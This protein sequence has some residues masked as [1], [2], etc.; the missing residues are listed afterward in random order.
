[1]KKVKSKR[2]LA[3]IMVLVLLAVNDLSFAAFAD[4]PEASQEI[5]ATG[6][7][8]PEAS[9]TVP[10]ETDLPVRQENTPASEQAEISQ[11]E[12]KAAQEETQSVPEK[13]EPI[14]EENPSA[15]SAQPEDEPAAQDKPAPEETPA[16]PETGGAEEIDPAPYADS[17]AITINYIFKD[18]KAMAARPHIES[19][20]AGEAVSKSISSPEVPGYEPLTFSQLIEIPSMDKDVSYDVFYV[21]KGNTPYKVN[22]YQQDLDQS[23]Y[24]L[25][26]VENRRGRTGTAVTAESQRYIGFTDP[27]V[28]PSAQISP[29]GNTELNVYYT[30][31]QYTMFFNTGE[32]GSYIEPVTALYDQPLTLP[33]DPTRPGYSFAGWGAYGFPSRMPVGDIMMTAEWEIAGTVSYTLV[34]WLESIEGN[35]RYDH[36][37]A[38]QISGPAESVP[39]IPDSLPGGIHFPIDQKHFTFNE[40]K[41]NEEKPA[42]ISGTGE[43]IVN[44]FYDRK[45]YTL[46]FEFDDSKYTL[47]AGGKTYNTSPYTLTAKYGAPIADQW[48]TEAP[49][50]RPGQ[51]DSGTFTGWIN[52]D[53]SLYF[54]SVQFFLDE[55]HINSNP[56][57]ANWKSN[58]RNVT[59]TY[60]FENLAGNGETADY[61]QALNVARESR[62]WTAKQFVGFTPTKNRE[63]ITS[64]NTATFHY[65]RNRYQMEF[66]NSGVIDRTV[67]S[68]KYEAPISGLNYTPGTP[69]SL[70]GYTFGGWFTTPQ[71]FPGSEYHFTGKTMPAYNLI[72]YAKWVKPT[73][74]VTFMPGN[75][76]PS[77]S[78]RILLQE[79][80]EEPAHPTRPG[81]LFA[82]W[83][84][85]GSP[86]RYVFPAVTDDT[87]LTAKWIPI[88]NVGYDVLYKIG[89]PADS[90]EHSRVSYSGKTVDTDVTAYAI[91]IPG[92]LP[93]AMSKTITLSLGGNRIIFYYAPFT[94]AEYT[95]RYV[96]SAT[97]DPLLPDKQVQT[98]L[99]EVRE[100]YVHI[101][102]YYPDRYEQTLPISPVP[103]DNVLVFNYTK[104]PDAAYQV[105][106]YLEQPD[107][108]YY[109][110]PAST[111][112]LTAPVGSVQSAQP[113]SFAHYRYA[114]DISTPGGMVLADGSTTLRLYYSLDTYTVNYLAGPNGSL[115]GRKVFSDIKHGAPYG[116]A[117]PAPVPRP[118]Q[119]YRFAGWDIALPASG[120]PVTADASYTARFEIDPAQWAAV[121][122][123][124]N[125][126][127]GT[128][129]DDTVLIG[130]AYTLR[131][132]AFTRTNHQFTGWDTTPNASGAAYGE[133]D[134]LTVKGDVTLYADWVPDTQYTV[135]YIA[136]GGTGT[137][138]DPGNP[139]FM[140]DPVTVLP[141]SYTRTGYLFSE[142]TTHQDG[143]G[144]SY[145][146]AD[147]FRI[148]ANTTLYAQWIKDPSQWVTIRFDKNSPDATGDMPDREVLASKPFALPANQ[149]ALADNDFTGWNS[150]NTGGGTVLANEGT[151]TPE[152]AFPLQSQI[153]LYAQWRAHPKYTVSYHSNTPS[154]PQI[155]TDAAPYKEGSPVRLRS[156]NTFSYPHHTFTHWTESPS[157]GTPYLPGDS[158]PI[159]R[160]MIF[161]ARWRENPVFHVNYEDPHSGDTY[162]DPSTYHIDP[163]GSDPVT[164][165]ENMFVRRGYNFAGW[166]VEFQN[167]IGV[168]SAANPGNVLREAVSDIT[169]YARWEPQLYEITYDLSGGR[170]QGVNP[171][172][173]HIETPTF[174]LMN[175]ERLGYTFLGWSG[176]DLNPLLPS[177]SVTILRGST[178]SRHYT[179]HWAKDPAQWSKII[180]ETRDPDKGT[181]SG[182][183]IFEGIKNTPADTVTAPETNPAAGYAFSAWDR[184]IPDSFPDSDITIYA[185]WAKDPAQWSKITFETRDPGKGT[186][187]GTQS[188]EGIKNTPS[189]T[190]SAPGTN[191]AAGYAFST[192]D[193]AIPD[194]FPDSDITIYADWAK[195]PAQWSKIIFET[196]DPDKGTLSGMQSF[197]GIKNTPADTVTAPETNPAAGYA[198]S[199]WDRAIPGSFPDSDITIYADWEKDPTQW[200]KIIFETRDPGKGTL[201][202]TQIF[203]G[204]KGTPADTVTA[205]GTNPAAGYVFSAWDRA[206]PDSYPDSDITIYADW[207]KDPANPPFV[208][209][210]KPPA[211]PPVDPPANPPADPPTDTPAKPVSPAEPVLPKPISR[212]LPKTGDTE[213]LLLWMVLAVAAG[214][215]LAAVKPKS[216]K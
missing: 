199:A 109:Q 209:P 180:F 155:V 24:T 146:P 154:L 182:T 87:T 19:V 55:L 181:L 161:Y 205:P 172:E 122:Y 75:G 47:R 98:S 54:S 203:E 177:D 18:S 212:S 110:D 49:R 59:V 168:R 131:P 92:F 80:A 51:T 185:D 117:A 66:Y 94:G 3:F 58:T 42:A 164:V 198:F 15:A 142:W 1:M 84:K 69:P 134:T 163:Q 139:Y 188:F 204:I 108:R 82:G 89:T 141:N 138:A 214:A 11:T 57:R 173:Y 25:A 152:T 149:Y 136:N 127:S 132:N 7:L 211:K 184:A 17:Y 213:N 16:V 71:A 118:A 79:K 70:P 22:H 162:H 171:S 202:G 103:E 200:S 121:S 73:Y 27:A 102:G 143:T 178:G 147:S 5:P 128:M 83:Y 160:N 135:T 120:T 183:Q 86:F 192:W 216:K 53:S 133:G 174:T 95:V 175:P 67:S 145:S 99:S 45:A 14:Q 144:T 124:P 115:P 210:I 43:T 34:Y 93:D 197:E 33:P 30:R 4:E 81:Y 195:D 6:Q 9:E 193:R 106:H 130:T 137:V 62:E 37:G 148:T 20:P 150:R 126:G 12:E 191:P 31:N 23:S 26:M 90:V 91:A 105:T 28:M 85:T 96:D 119:G 76:S 78:Q 129:T 10:P 61:E 46:S 97:G 166:E 169:L 186:L 40:T 111:E 159:D 44:V 114:A 101:S 68:I 189:D 165:K 72:L 88:N 2:I 52:Q 8:L 153:T 36:V 208:P 207:E 77:F 194:S 156:A 60:L 167:A 39:V 170:M 65:T 32:G 112:N 206:I 41:T 48:P 113:K 104:N 187:S 64:E 21:P 63:P 74:T 56:F 196:R 38:A 35:G 50:L 158:F 125:G 215:M 190:V 116:T 157:A 151:F 123:H 201:S 107:G 176:T 140:N 179:A 100:A 29:D 13:D